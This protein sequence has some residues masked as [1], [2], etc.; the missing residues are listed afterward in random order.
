MPWH[1][2]PPTS[3]EIRNWQIAALQRML[4]PLSSVWPS[5][6]T[7]LLIASVQVTDAKEVGEILVL[8]ICE[9]MDQLQQ[10]YKAKESE[11]ATLHHEEL[12][13]L[14][15]ECDQQIKLAKDQGR[16]LNQSIIELRKINATLQQKVDDQSKLITTQHRQLSN[17]MGTPTSE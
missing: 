9:L 5:I 1:N 7:I 2:N 15:R 13:R 12:V 14:K 10:D 11:A 4:Q 8:K 3:E 16:Q 6:H 17:I